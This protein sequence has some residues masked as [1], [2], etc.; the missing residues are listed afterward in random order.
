MLGPQSRDANFVL[1]F[2]WAWWWLGILVA[3]PFVGRLWC[4]VCPFMIYGEVAQKLSLWLFPRKTYCPGRARKPSGGAAG[5]C[6]D[7]SP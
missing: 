6:S 7:C 5:S 2:F 4:S 1:N 3:F